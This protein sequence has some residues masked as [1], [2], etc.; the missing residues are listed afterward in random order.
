MKPVL[1]TRP[2]GALWSRRN[3]LRLVAA[4]LPALAT[5]AVPTFSG[6]AEAGYAKPT[7]SNTGVSAGITLKVHRGDIVVTT[8]GKVIQNLDIYGRVL[9]RAANV[10]VKNCRIRGTNSPSSNTGLV[11]CN[12]KYVKNA[13]IERCLLKPDRATVWLTGVIGKEYTA[14]WNNVYNVVDGFGAYNI[15][16]RTSPTNV[17]IESNYIHDLSYFSSDPNHG[18]GPTHNDCIQIQGGSNVVIV[19]NNIQCFMSTTAGTQNYPARNIGQGIVVTPNVAPVTGSTISYNW[20]DGGK[21]SLYFTKGKFGSQKFG[22]CA[23]NRFG[24]NQYKFNGTSQYQ[25]RVQTGI[26]F[27]NSLTQNVWDATGAA[28]SVSS[29]G[30]IRYA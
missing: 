2:A 24:K 10:V 17:R 15:S 3:A 5:V 1:E 26:T 18:G 14:R 12:H 16:S 25:I 30:G 13:L 20:L 9:I 6:L 22:A 8:P 4:T 23:Y 28:L 29:T 19:G 27:S 21:A 7:A 11:D